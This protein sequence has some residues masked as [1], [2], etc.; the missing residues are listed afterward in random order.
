MFK[1]LSEVPTESVRWLWEGRIPLG[2]LTLIEGE[3]GLG[4]STL[5]LDLASKVSRGVA[6]PLSKEPPIGPANVI[7][8]SGDDTLGDTVKPRLEAAQADL[9][10]IYAIDREIEPI[11]VAELRPALII[12]DP[13]S[14]YICLACERNPVEVM[15]KLA[16]MARQTG[17]AILA[18]QSVTEKNDTEHTAEFYATPRSVLM[19]TPIGHGGRR[20]AISKSNLRH[21]PD[22]PP[23][24][25]YFDD[26]DGPVHIV[27]WTDGR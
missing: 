13:L 20:L 8:Y 12:L 9:S 14:A 6:M 1:R 26:H 22:I 18:L 17:A 4:K 24:V 3:P 25:Y 16:D 5:A 15:R 19:L 23:I 2:K 27:N 21:I 11:D 10:R 7:L